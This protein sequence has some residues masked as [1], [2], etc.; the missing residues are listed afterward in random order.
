MN[1]I[2]LS[3]TAKESLKTL[4]EQLNKLGIAKTVTEFSGS[5]DSGDLN[6]TVYYDA[7]DQ[8]LDVEVNDIHDV[9]HAVL[10]NYG[11]DWYNNDGGFGTVTF[12][13]K[14]GKINVDMN[15]NEQHSTAHPGTAKL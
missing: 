4:F 7:D 14:Q 11:Y 8:V 2:K 6:G 10:K 12:H 5:G 13:P 15:I 3:D 1:A 9:V